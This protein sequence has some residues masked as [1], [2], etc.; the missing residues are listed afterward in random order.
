[1]IKLQSLV[2]KK[3]TKPAKP[4]KTTKKSLKPP[5]LPTP[6]SPSA[7]PID[8]ED[9]VEELYSQTEGLDIEDNDPKAKKKAKAAEIARLATFSLQDVI[10]EAKPLKEVQ[11]EAFNPREP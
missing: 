5:A 6:A 10:E 9:A 1:M 8:L 11:F 2:P 3:P 4:A 7:K